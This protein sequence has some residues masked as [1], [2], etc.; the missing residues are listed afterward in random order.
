MDGTSLAV[1]QT[2]PAV[3][4]G[5]T[6][7]TVARSDNQDS[8]GRLTRVELLRNYSYQVATTSRP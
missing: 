3:T 5:P 2:P 6:M 4:T 1:L 7:Y 8:N